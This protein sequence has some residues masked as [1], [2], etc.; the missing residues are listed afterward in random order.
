MLL[1]VL[2]FLTGLALVAAGLFLAWQGR[3]SPLNIFPAGAGGLPILLIAGGL[4][5]IAG[6]VFLVSALHPRP[7][8]TLAAAETAAREDAALA[9]AETYY[10]E[11]ARAA[12]RDWRA[13]NIAPPSLVPIPAPPTPRPP[14]PPPANPFPAS[15]TLAPVARGA[16]EAPAAY[17]E[18]R[19][20]IAAGRLDEANRLLEA[21]R[22]TA[23]GIDLAH[24]TALAGQHAAAAGQPS[25]ARW[26][27]RLA[28]KRFGEAD[29]LNTPAAISVTESLRTAS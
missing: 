25:H 6:L 7:N 3:A 2:H 4:A 29:A 19:S 5:V 28:L 26:L 13:A 23:A 8:Q 9:E 22:E 11:R 14:P 27:W 17:P 15:V 21:A 24:L 16:A 18:I 12:D 1:R 10:S 20:A